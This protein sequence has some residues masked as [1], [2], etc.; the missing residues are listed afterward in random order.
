M[1]GLAGIDY[2]GGG[3][4]APMA[5]LLAFMKALVNGTL[6]SAE[7]LERMKS[8]KARLFPEFDYGYGIWQVRPI[9]VLLPAKYRSWG[10]LG[11][12]GAFM[13]YHPELEAYLIGT[14]NHGA[15]QKKAVRFMFKI[16]NALWEEFN[17]KS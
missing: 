4:V 10:V 14:F 1:K 5:E 13:F 8:D 15:Y 11:S 12:T 7:T 6:V 2:A 16:I 17:R 3:V 9:P